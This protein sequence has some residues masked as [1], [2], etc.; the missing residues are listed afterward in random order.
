MKETSHT[1]HTLIT[2]LFKM[3]N[4]KVSTIILHKAVFCLDSK[5]HSV[6]QSFSLIGKVRSQLGENFA[7]S[8]VT[9]TPHDGRW[10]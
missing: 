1:S 10:R 9:L 2:Q 3:R 7:N 4:C 8:D 6:W 5:K